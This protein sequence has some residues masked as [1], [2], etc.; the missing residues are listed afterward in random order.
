MAYEGYSNSDWARTV[1]TTLAEHVREVEDAWMRNFAF[2]AMIQSR[3]Q[4]KYNCGG[5]GF[6]WPVRYRNGDVEG[7]TGT[8]PRNFAAKNRWKTAQLDYRGYHAT[9]F[10]NDRELQENKGEAAIIKVSEGMIQRLEDD[11]MEALA[12]EPFNDGNA[13]GYTQL[14]HGMDSFFGLNGTVNISTGAQRSANAADKVGYPS[15]TYAGLSTILGNYGGDQ[16][17]GVVWPAGVADAEYDFWSP[18]VVNYTS[19]AFSGTADTWAAQG[20][21]ALR[22]AIL[23]SQRNKTP[24]GGIGH[25][26]LDRTL[27]GDSLNSLDSKEQI[28]ITSQ[29][30]LRALGF[31]QSFM[32]DGVEVT[33]EAAIP[34]TVGYGVNFSNIQLRC[35]NSQ[36]FESEGPEWDIDSGGYKA[37]IKTLS[38]LE[39][40]SPRNYFKLDNVA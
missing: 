25:V 7:Y 1:A 32:Y 3:G 29:T 21:E 40:S 8:N 18:L 30:E 37:L 39:F 28:N 14:W 12:T 38:N 9:D 34:S 16:E 22:F 23:H 13:T 11:M 15:D 20:L 4:V 35:M 17:S 5:R 31:G 36:L 24:K 26:F 10:I 33:W 2:L 6:D 19:T 27:Y